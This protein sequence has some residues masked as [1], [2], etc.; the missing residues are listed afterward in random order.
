MALTLGDYIY[1]RLIPSHV[2]DV[3]MNVVDMEILHAQVISPDAS[4]P[5]LIRAKAECQLSG[6]SA[7]T[8][9][10]W[11]HTKG[12]EKDA[13]DEAF[14]SCKVLYEDPK[15]WQREWSRVAHLVRSRVDEL[16]RLAAEGRDGTNRL[17]R[18]MAYTLFRNVVDYAD[19]YRGMQSVVLRDFEAVSDVALGDDSKIDEGGVWHSPPHCID[20][21]FHIGGLVLNGSDASNTRDFFYVTPGWGSCRMLRRFRANDTFR[22]Y[23]RMSPMDDGADPALKNMFAGDVYAMQ[24]GQIVAML[25]T[26]KFRRVP[27]VL[28]SSLFTP[29]ASAGG[30][31]HVG[32]VRAPVTAPVREVKPEVAPVLPPVKPKSVSVEV[33]QTE[34]A[35]VTDAAPASNG[36][37]DA[38]MQLICRETGLT[39][40]QLRDEATFVQLGVDSLMS[41]VL[42]EKLRGELGLDIKSS[43][44]LECPDIKA[45]K[46]WLS[47]YC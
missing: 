41:L 27:R 46:E 14:A 12:T 1:K 31:V 40:D 25:G 18:N 2:G 24:D 6:S 44:F 26:M 42:S 30:P 16:D 39:A 17:S 9:I 43:L 23:V 10:T 8:E 38:C 28:M 3:A 19:S 21:V 45:L 13:T 11:Y 37:V 36:V 20:S 5:H 33:P 47:Q 32:K 34:A 35:A 15:E 22:S 7:V 29:A 4:T